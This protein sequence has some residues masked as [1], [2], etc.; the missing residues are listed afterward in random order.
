MAIPGLFG[1]SP[2]PQYHLCLVKCIVFF[3]LLGYIVRLFDIG[4][5]VLNLESLLKDAH[6]LYKDVY[7][8]DR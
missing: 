7:N 1:L 4:N 8:I 5:K 6:N 3:I 2:S